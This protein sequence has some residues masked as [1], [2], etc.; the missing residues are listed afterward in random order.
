MA[1]AQELGEILGFA[2]LG[3]GV[4]EALGKTGKLGVD[5][6]HA[7]LGGFQ[8][9]AQALQLAGSNG[10]GKSSLIR[11]LAGLLRPLVGEVEREG[12]VGLLDERPALDPGLPLGQ[13]LGFWQ[14]DVAAHLFSHF[15]EGLGDAWRDLVHDNRE[16][17]RVVVQT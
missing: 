15:L 8:A 5:A 11:I 2:G 14:R 6:G 10:I 13:A 12:S 3:L 1:K 7:G 9:T 16:P 4:F 17:G